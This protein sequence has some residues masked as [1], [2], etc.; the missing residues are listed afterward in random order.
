VHY[1]NADLDQ[2]IDQARVTIDQDQRMALWR[3]VHRILHEDQP[4]TFLWT[5]RSV[6]F[7]DKRIHNVQRVK[8][9][10]NHSMHWFVP[11]GAQRW[12]R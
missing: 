1:Q 5:S 4:Y 9:G 12:S 6:V 8:T 10:L 3:K 11:L 2:L 7:L